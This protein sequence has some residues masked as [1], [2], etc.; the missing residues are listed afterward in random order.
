MDGGDDVETCYSISSNEYND[1]GHNSGNEG[2]GSDRNR[3]CELCWR[4][5][6]NGDVQGMCCCK[7]CRRSDGKKHDVECDEEW[8]LTRRWKLE[9][10]LELKL[11]KVVFRSWCCSD[12]PIVDMTVGPLEPPPL[13]RTLPGQGSQ[14]TDYAAPLDPA[15]RESMTLQTWRLSCWEPVD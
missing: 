14:W 4:P 2:S 13:R 9:K 5:N 10:K 1:T 3:V 8:L 12:V 7:E 11:L 6:P 15:M